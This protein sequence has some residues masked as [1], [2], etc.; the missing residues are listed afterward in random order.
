MKRKVNF[1]HLKQSRKASPFKT[2]K[3]QVRRLKIK[4]F[5]L[6]TLPVFITTLARTV[7]KEYSR[8]KIRQAAA[9]FTAFDK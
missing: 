8:A 1:L 2:L 3:K 6:I 4:L 9:R 5:L 7:W